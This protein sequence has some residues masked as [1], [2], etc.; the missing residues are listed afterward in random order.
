MNIYYARL[1]LLDVQLEAEAQVRKLEEALR[2]E[3]DRQC[4]L[5]C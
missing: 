5:L 4:P 1:A 2:L 3:R